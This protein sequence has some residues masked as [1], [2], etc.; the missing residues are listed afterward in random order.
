MLLDTA[1]LVLD[2]IPL[3]GNF[4]NW[5]TLTTFGKAYIVV[6]LGIPHQ[7]HE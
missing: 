5:D 6:R 2:F 1:D 3:H 7:I 4:G